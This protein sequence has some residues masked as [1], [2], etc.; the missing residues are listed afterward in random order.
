MQKNEFTFLSADRKTP[1]HTVEW[2]PEGAP[3]A[4][5]QLSHGVSEYID[6]YE[7]FASYLTDRGFAVVGNDHIGHGKSMAP[8]AR[9]LYFGPEGSWN[10]V[11]DDLYA[12]RDLTG[13]RFPGLPYFLLGHSMGSFLARTYLIR[14]PGMVD[15]AILM[16][17]GQMAPAMIA[18]G[19]LIARSQLKKVGADGSSPVVDRL[20][21]GSYNKLFAPNRTAFDWLSVNRDNVDRY[22]EDPLCGGSASTG[23]FLEMLGGIR[24]NEKPE[25]LRRMNM[26]TPILFVSGAMDPVGSCG[27][28]VRKACESFRKA[29]VRQVAMKLY[30]GLRH[31]ILNEDCGDLVYR[32]LYEWLAAK[33]PE[34]VEEPAR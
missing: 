9:P 8:G 25:N 16:G 26:T 7:G 18:A 33:L 20:A 14:Y 30:P 11:V 27:K 21:F 3:R 4:V 15:G 1:I 23:L 17:T 6:R 29:G 19:R 5:L 32:D 28:D 24:F 13:H 22:V 2:L 12:L 10:L 34:R 31:E